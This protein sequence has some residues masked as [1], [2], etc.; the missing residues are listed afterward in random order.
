MLLISGTKPNKINTIKSLNTHIGRPKALY[1]IQF[2]E[3]LEEI[4]KGCWQKTQLRPCLWTAP[5]HS[6][7]ERIH[8]HPESREEDGLQ[9]GV[10]L[11]GLRPWCFLFAPRSELLCYSSGFVPIASEL[12]S[13]YGGLYIAC[14]I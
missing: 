7:Q 10:T 3:F 2:L 1:Y 11:P 13:N 14:W 6:N 4:E 5:N 9:E 12:I 8:K